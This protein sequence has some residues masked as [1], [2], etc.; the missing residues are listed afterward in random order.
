MTPQRKR[1]ACMKK[2]LGA[3]PLLYPSPVCVVGTYDAVGKPNAAVAAWAGIA[4]SSPPCISVSFRKQ[5]QTYKNILHRKAFT[6]SIPSISRVKEADFFGIA[7]GDEY[8]KFALTGLTPAQSQ[9]VDAPYVEEFPLVLECKLLQTVELGL[10]TMFVGEILDVKADEAVL[11]SPDDAVSIQK[12]APL[13]YAHDTREYYTIGRF[14]A[15]AFL[16]GRDFFSKK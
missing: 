14:I 10:H 4:C 11:T 9:F 5:T 6:V 16:A 12:V 2:S 13:I 3:R 7:S 8:D 1:K 15:K